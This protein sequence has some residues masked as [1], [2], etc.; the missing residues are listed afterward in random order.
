MSP[1]VTLLS[2]A[3]AAAPAPVVSHQEPDPGAIQPLAGA[4]GLAELCAR[5]VP[6]EQLRAAGDAV[7]RGEAEARHEG[8][9]DEALAARYQLELPAARLAF[10]PYDASERRLAVA[11]AAPLAVGPRAALW[12]AAARGLPVQL[13]AGAARRILEAQRAGR[14]G[15]SLVFDLAED[16]TCSNGRPGAA[17]LLPVEPVEWSWTDGARVLARGGAAADRPAVDLAGGARPRVDVGEPISGPQELKKAVLARRA[18]LEACYTAALEKDPA[19]DGVVV[20]ELTPSATPEIAADSTGAPELSAC[21]GRALSTLAPPAAGRAAVPI[22]FDLVAP[23][24]A[25]PP[26]GPAPR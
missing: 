6:P 3:L 25:A 10:A 9:R 17:L 23:A 7:D 24:A 2:S 8:A 19:V 13:D 22:R 14:L 21:V 12:L 11:E 16:A 18:D 4:A 5:L 20:V 15:L 1:L 26:P